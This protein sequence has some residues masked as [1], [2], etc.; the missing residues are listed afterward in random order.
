MQ[1]LNIMWKPYFHWD[2]R[3]FVIMNDTIGFTKKFTI[4]FLFFSILTSFELILDF[5][6]EIA[7]IGFLNSE[8]HAG[9]LGT[10]FRFAAAVKESLLVFIGE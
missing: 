9:Y 7:D 1:L 4:S 8:L 10:S 6:S 3:E 2:K 5:L